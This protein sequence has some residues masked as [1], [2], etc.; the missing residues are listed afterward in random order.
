[1][2]GLADAK[3]SFVCAFAIRIPKK[4]GHAMT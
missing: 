3:G 4:Q 1:M 2:A